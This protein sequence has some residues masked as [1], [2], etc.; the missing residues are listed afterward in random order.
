MHSKASLL[1]LPALLAWG[2]LDPIRPDTLTTPLPGAIRGTIKDF[3]KGDLLAEVDVL[4]K[5]II[6]D[7]YGNL[8]LAVTDSSGEFRFS[9][10]EPGT[11]QLSVARS[12]FQTTEKSVVVTSGSRKQVNLALSKVP[13]SYPTDVKLDVLFVVDNSASMEQEQKALGQGFPSFLNALLR[14]NFFMDLRVGVISTDMGAGNYQLDGCSSGGDGGKLQNAPRSPGCAPLPDPYISVHGNKTN[15]P[16]DNVNHAFACMVQLGVDGCGFEQPLAAIE[17]AVVDRVVPG[18]PRSDSALA[19]VVVTDEDDCSAAYPQLFDPTNQDLNGPLGPLTSFRCF[20]F[21]VKCDCLHSVKCHRTTTGQR[22][23][24]RAGGTYLKDVNEF[25]RQL[26]STRAMD[27]LFFAVIAGPIDKVVVGTEKNNP[28]LD[29]SCTSKTGLAMPSIRLQDVTQQLM[30][31][32]SFDSICSANLK[33]PMA[34][35]ADLIAKT[36]LLHPCN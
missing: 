27:K 18:F 25:V 13:K 30:P 33:T 24:C 15:V 35:L 5:R 17:R 21:G 34:N 31:S 8:K 9:N 3:C 4:A 26:S 29:A 20:E 14:Y 6:G 7:G 23:N 19:I 1:L 2:C 36:S 11:W 16:G 32:S 10:I 12:G 28:V 22:F